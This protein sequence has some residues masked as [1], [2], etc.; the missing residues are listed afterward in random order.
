[1]LVLRLVNVGLAVPDHQGRGVGRAMLDEA[2]PG[3]GRHAVVVGQQRLF[4]REARGKTERGENGEECPDGSQAKDSRS[5][6][7]GC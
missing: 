4:R 2:D 5:G 7:Q 1:M 3:E 6:L